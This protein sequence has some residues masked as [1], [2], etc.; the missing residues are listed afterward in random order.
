M[1]DI[2]KVVSE[3][4]KIISRPDVDED[5]KNIIKRYIKVCNEFIE[6][7]RTA[8]NEAILSFKAVVKLYNPTA[9]SV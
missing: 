8:T 7:K 4:N 9:F 2:Q 1:S 6:K 5:E 3:F